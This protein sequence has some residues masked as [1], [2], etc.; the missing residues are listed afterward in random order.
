MQYVRP[1]ATIVSGGAVVGGAAPGQ[2]RPPVPM[3]SIAGRGRGDWRP[4]GMNKGLPTMQKNIHPGFG[5]PIWANNSSGR[6]F[7]T[8]MEFTLPSHKYV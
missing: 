6:A 2:V 5:M 1:G 3:G 4:I 7:G 8:G